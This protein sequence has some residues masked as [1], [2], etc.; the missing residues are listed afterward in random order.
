M[1]FEYISQVESSSILCSYVS[2]GRTEVCHLLEPIHA[3]KDRIKTIGGQSTMAKHFLIV[4]FIIELRSCKLQTKKGTGMQD[5]VIVVL[6]DHA[7]VRII[8]GVCF[9]DSG[10][11]RVEV[12]GDS[13]ER[14]LE[15]FEGIISGSTPV[16]GH[17]L[18]QEIGNRNDDT[19]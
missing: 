2:C 13:G 15:P 14:L 19:S 8:Q 16:K 12:I 7:T 5:S 6:G 18:F 3:D 11:R 17:A 1:M 10:A 9:Q 4:D